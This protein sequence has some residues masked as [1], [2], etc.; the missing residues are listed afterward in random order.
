MPRM[1]GVTARAEYETRE[2]LLPRGV[3]RGAARQL[4]TEQAEY[5]GWELRAAAAVPRRH[6]ARCG[7]AAG[8]SGSARTA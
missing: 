1:V 4:L 3:S 7:C 6:P 2:M 5:G 8:S